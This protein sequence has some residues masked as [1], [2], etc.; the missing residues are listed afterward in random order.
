M[1][2]T[3]LKCFPLLAA[4][5]L[6]GCRTNLPATER[7]RADSF[8][9]YQ[10]LKVDGQ[11]IGL[12]LRQRTAM[13]VSH[14]EVTAARPHAQYMEIDF[15]PDSKAENK[16]FVV[17]G[18]AAAIQSD[19]Y[20]LTAAH[21]VDGPV[22]Y[23]VFFDGRDFC[24]RRIRVVA[25]QF[26]PDKLLDCAIIHVDAILP[27]VFDWADNQN[28]KTGDPV[29]AVGYSQLNGLAP[30]I[31]YVTQ[32]CLGGRIVAGAGDGERSRRVVA[33]IPVRHGDSGGPVV[34]LDAK[35][36]GPSS[37]ASNGDHQEIIDIIQ[38]PDRAWIA[39]AIEQDR[40]QQHQ[41]T[42]SI[43]A[44]SRPGD[45]RIPTLDVAL[46]SDAP[47]NGAEAKSSN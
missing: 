35:L 9:P 18:H 45:A 43:P 34:T 36:I 1:T 46:W 11:E 26:E 23:L 38:R 13:I 5:L 47:R 19:G 40:A 3:A 30:S 8:Q 44:T 31:P 33:G 24:I 21:C 37:F 42:P 29:I 32:S 22:N 17:F 39:R 12:F 41:T 2:R 20:F 15:K 4:I 28:I 6:I 16:F 27:A 7:Q 10:A 14:G 25:R